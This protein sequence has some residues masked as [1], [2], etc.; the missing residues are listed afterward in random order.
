MIPG[1]MTVQGHHQGVTCPR[2]NSMMSTGGS[3]RTSSMTPVT[4]WELRCV[5]CAQRVPLNSRPRTSSVGRPREMPGLRDGDRGVAGPRSATGPSDADRETP[6]RVC[7]TA[8]RRGSNRERTRRK[9]RGEAEQP[10]TTNRGV[11]VV[12]AVAGLPLP[13]LLR[14]HRLRH[15]L[16]SQPRQA[17]GQREVVRLVPFLQRSRGL[18]EADSPDRPEWIIVVGESVPCVGEQRRDALQPRCES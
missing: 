3:P 5:S 18:I 16:V 15:L 1:G 7:A 6:L 9:E 13:H 4:S 17:V 8:P 14:R 10:H 11:G 2:A 12:L